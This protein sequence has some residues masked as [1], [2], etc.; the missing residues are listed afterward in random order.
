MRSLQGRFR[1]GLASGVV[2]FLNWGHVS[3]VPRSLIRFVPTACALG[4]R[5]GLA[6]RERCPSFRNQL[7]RRD[8]ATAPFGHGSVFRPSGLQGE[9]RRRIRHAPD[10][11]N[12]IKPQWSDGFNVFADRLI[13][14]VEV[15]RSLGRLAHG[16][17]K[18][19]Y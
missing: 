4:S 13:L 8:R 19:W 1:S 2:R 16:R 12:R 18:R 5:R 7:H 10:F 14:N 11:W 3:G 15:A 9:K 17:P 6:P